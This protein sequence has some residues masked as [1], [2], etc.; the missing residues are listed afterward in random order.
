MPL[1]SHYQMLLRLL[2]H[3]LLCRCWTWMF[4]PSLGA[5]A[6]GIYGLYCLRKHYIGQ[7]NIFEQLAIVTSTITCLTLVPPGFVNGFLEVF[8][9]KYVDN[10][11]EPTAGVQFGPYRSIRHPIYASTML[12]FVSYF[13]A[14]RAPLSMLFVIAVCLL[15]Y[16]QKAKLEESLMLETFGD[17]YTEYMSK[18][19]PTE[20]RYGLA[21]SLKLSHCMTTHGT[22]APV[23]P[24]Y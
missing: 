24:S 2:D 6:I 13:V 17:G 22:I 1:D 15:Y 19:L 20:G 21:S 12:L 23:L 3:H 11:T 18:L 10:T 5:L 9:A 8:L 16:G 14:L 4:W 7:A